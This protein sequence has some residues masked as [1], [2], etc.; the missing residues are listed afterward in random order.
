M[1][2][3]VRLW[4]FRVAESSVPGQEMPSVLQGVRGWG[5]RNA[6]LQRRLY[7]HR[8]H[9]PLCYEHRQNRLVFHPGAD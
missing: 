6:L 2:K 3:K 1:R 8:L 5:E 4:L 9:F 7:G